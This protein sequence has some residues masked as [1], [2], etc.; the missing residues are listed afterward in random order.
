MALKIMGQ[1]NKKFNIMQYNFQKRVIILFAI[2]Y[3]T[4]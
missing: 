2:T 1:I 4:F 3:Y